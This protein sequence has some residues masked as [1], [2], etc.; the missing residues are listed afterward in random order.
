MTIE[1]SGHRRDELANF[2]DVA[3]PGSSMS[4]WVR[5]GVLWRSDAP[6]P[7]D[8]A[9][10]WAREHDDVVWPP[11]LV[12]DLRDVAEVGDA[13]HPL[14]GSGAE[15]LNLPLAGSLAPAQQ[16]ALRRGRIGLTELYR[17]L[18]G[19]ADTWLPH[20]VSAVAH[21]DGPTLVHCAAGKDRTGV[22]VALL[23]R[24]AGVPR[25]EILADYLATRD[26]LPDLRPRLGLDE[27]R[28]AVMEHLLD[29]SVPA[30][31]AVLEEVGADPVT[32]HRDRGVAADDIARWQ[33]RV[34]PGRAGG[35]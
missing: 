13:P 6:L 3:P 10:S 5:T 4:R 29:V 11:G 32:F 25:A 27:T 19:S 2:R 18:L 8:V 26:A 12:V 35:H 31:T 23:L 9:P 21:A 20:L 30:L 33:R 1:H 17:Q 24:L 15:I 14:A 22:S 34:R 28:L 16:L 7:D